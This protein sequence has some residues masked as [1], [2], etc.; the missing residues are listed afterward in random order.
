MPKL[1]RLALVG[2]RSPLV[3]S[4]QR[5][6]G[7]LTALTE[8]E[9]LPVD[10]YW[11][12]TTDVGDLTGFDGVWLLPGSPYASE[13]GALSA[14]TQARENGL[15]FLGSCGGFQHA[16]LEFARNVCGLSSAQ[17]GENNPEGDDLIV[18]PLACSLAGHQG[19]VQLTAGSIA[20]SLLGRGQTFERYF[21]R[22]G[23]NP[24]YVQTLTS[25]GLVFSGHDTE[26]DVRI[27]ELPTHPFYLA[28]L[29]QPE[30]ADGPRPHPFIRAFATAATTHAMA[31][32]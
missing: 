24:A 31:F 27:A 21:C 23:V 8:T 10:A 25:H 12:P 3:Q 7:V 14:V 17:H 5:I 32:L 19:A 26:G 4:H 6:P 1:P 11:I 28:A 30:L 15:P 18:V 29:F 13:T 9:Q 20:E 22:Y 2:D 16:L